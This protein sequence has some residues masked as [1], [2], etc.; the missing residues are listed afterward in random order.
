MEHWL[1][2]KRV[3]QYLAGTPS[4]G[5]VY[6]KGG[7]TAEA[8]GDADYAADV[9]T[10]RSRSGSLVI[11]NGGALLWSSKLQATVST[12][13]CEAK[14]IASAASA[15]GA[16]WTRMLL[17]EL[18]GNVVPMRLHCDNSAALI[19]MTEPAAGMAGKKHVE[20]AYQFV[21]NRVMR[22]ELEVV[23]VGTGE[24]LADMFTKPLPAPRFA[25]CCSAIGMGEL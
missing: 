20:V 18:S 4:I 8:F 22:G 11:K 13:T 12:L 14:Y 6:K 25:E 21:R 1:A 15:K 3:L 16:L 7:A 2:A 23:F 5:I 17:G 9:D 19:M 10:R 24:Q